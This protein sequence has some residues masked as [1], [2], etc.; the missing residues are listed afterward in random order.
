MSN[1]G[2]EN[3]RPLNARAGIFPPRISPGGQSIGSCLVLFLWLVAQAVPASAQI[4]A[5][6]SLKL[7]DEIADDILYTDFND[8]SMRL[9]LPRYR[10][11]IQ[12]VPGGSQYN[13]RF[14]GQGTAWR[15]EVHLEAYP[16][17]IRYSQGWRSPEEQRSDYRWSLRL[18][19]AR[20]NLQRAARILPH[21]ASVS[22]RYKP[23]PEDSDFK[24]TAFDEVTFEQAGLKAALNLNSLNARDDLIRAMRDS[25]SSMTL[26]VRRAPRIEFPEL[27]ARISEL[28]SAI[29]KYKSGYS[30]LTSFDNTCRPIYEKESKLLEQVRAITPDWYS[31]GDS[32]ASGW[33]NFAI[34]LEM[35]LNTGGNNEYNRCQYMRNSQDATRRG[36]Y[37]YYLQRYLDRLK[38]L[39]ALTAP[40]VLENVLP[41]NFDPV[42]YPYIVEALVPRPG[43]EQP[44]VR[45]T[46]PWQG[47]FYS[48]F[49]PPDH[50]D[51]WYYLPDR[52]ALDPKEPKVSVRFTGPADSQG[53]EM[54]YEAEPVADPAR[55][56]AVK[57]AL[58]PAPESSVSLEPLLI[59]RPQLWITLPVQGAGNQLQQRPDAS[60]DFR[61]GVKDRLQLTL[62]EF[63]RIYASLFG[64]AQTLLGGEVRFDWGAEQERV[65]FEARVIGQSPEAFWDRVISQTVFADYR[66]TIQVKSYGSAFAGDL[67]R[68]IVEFKDGDTVELRADKLEAAA[69]VRVPMRDYILNTASN[70]SYYYKVTSIRERNG[71]V[72]TKETP[73]WR[74]GVATILYPEA[75]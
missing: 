51:Q 65:P 63:Q 20:G 24:E 61:D 28:E 4:P 54:E 32:T 47:R 19:E 72:L 7:A 34:S 41:F 2:R 11:A 71:Q 66:K 62:E 60:V 8:P 73:T 23:N 26:V 37:E 70:K 55:I 59:D 33:I 64:G 57:S 75:P 13:V 68:L 67:K 21:S 50:M 38:P 46:L 52:F 74:A 10:L 53:V 27:G 3:L 42:L 1:A 69:A 39:R 22:L 14:S 49:R 25:G 12:T 17:V 48:Y 43:G 31:G 5:P 9:Y 18:I 44:L 15:L 6:A 29:E 30:D 56:E 36:Q 58:R 40:A 16:P 35:A 45:Y